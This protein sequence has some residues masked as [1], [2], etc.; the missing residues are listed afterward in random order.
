LIICNVNSLG[1]AIAGQI[2]ATTMLAALATAVILPVSL[3]KFTDMIDGTWTIAV[4]R[5]D[6]AGEEL[7]KALLSRPQGNRAV[8][9]VGNSIGARIII[10]AVVILHSLREEM[11]EEQLEGKSEA[12]CENNSKSSKKSS[13]FSRSTSSSSSSKKETSSKKKSK[14][15]IEIPA[16][17]KLQDFDDLVILLLLLLLLFFTYKYMLRID[18]K[19]QDVVVLGAPSTIRENKWTRIRSIVRGRVV[20]GYSEKDL[21]LSFVYRYER[22]KIQVAGVSPVPGEYYTTIYIH[23]CT[24]FLIYHLPFKI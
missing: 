17:F 14:Y 22:W 8:T 24:S 21:I 3:L 19:I 12:S 1:D 13:W 6:Q 18:F 4:E 9:L 20:N 23:T 10:K 16:N 15:N 7:A 5:A 11:R 2:I